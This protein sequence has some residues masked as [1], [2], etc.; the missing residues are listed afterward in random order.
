MGVALFLFQ[1]CAPKHFFQKQNLGVSFLFLCW[2]GGKTVKTKHRLF[3]PVTNLYEQVAWG[4]RE[5]GK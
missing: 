1:P 4:L 5:E 3:L 2:G